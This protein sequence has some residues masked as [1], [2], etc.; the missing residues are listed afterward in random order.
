MK[1]GKQRIMTK[2]IHVSGGTM[3]WCCNPM[4]LQQEKTIDLGKKKHVL[5][6]ERPAKGLLVKPGSVSPR[7][8][9]T[10]CISGDCLPG[11]KPEAGFCVTDANVKA[12]AY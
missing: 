4:T 6:G 12:R 7:W 3:A 9:I 5:V 2:V 10:T 1:C 8:S 11:E